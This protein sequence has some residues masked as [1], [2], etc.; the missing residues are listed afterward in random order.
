MESL[1]LRF[2][3]SNRGLSTSSLAAHR[4]FLPVGASRRGR[5]YPTA[6]RWNSRGFVQHPPRLSRGFQTAVCSR[7]ASVPRPQIA[8][9]G[10]ALRRRSRS[11]R[12]KA[13][14]APYNAHA[15]HV[16]RVCMQMSMQMS[17]V[18]IYYMEEAPALPLSSSRHQSQ[19]SPRVRCPCRVSRHPEIQ[20]RHD[21]RPAA[22][23]QRNETACARAVEA[24]KTA[25]LV[26]RGAA[27]GAAQSQPLH[28]LRAREA[29]RLIPRDVRTVAS[30]C[31]GNGSFLCRLVL[32]CGACAECKRY[33]RRA[34][35]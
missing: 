5:D 7:A 29:Q 32:F 1:R 33:G 3:G 9:Q 2:G 20:P 11:A 8:A 28:K 18:Y 21:K 25:D 15:T 23:R 35:Q 4:I 19:P 34:L 12:H 16:C 6:L 30:V 14:P 26:S 31:P 10:A 17:H 24:G 13:A 22:K 27:L